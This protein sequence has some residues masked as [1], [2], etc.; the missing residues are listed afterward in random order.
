MDSTIKINVAQENSRSVLKES[1]HNAPYKLVHYGSRNL[2]E[3][4]ELIIMSASPGVMD[5]DTLTIHMTLQ[6]HS[7]L[8][9]YTQAFNKLHPMQEGAQQLIEVNIKEDGLF[10]YIP[11]PTTPF[12]DSIYKTTN[13]IYLHKSATLIWGDIICGG[14]VHRN[15]CFAFTRLHSL[16]KVHVNGIPRYIDNQYLAPK[17]QPIKKMLFFEGYTHQGTLLY[18]SPYAREL[19]LELD[20][21]L[22]V[23]YDEITYGFTSC[24]DDMIMIRVLG[25]EGESLYNFM[26]MLGQLCWDYTTHKMEEKRTLSLTPIHQS[27]ESAKKSSVPKQKAQKITGKKATLSI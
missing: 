6:P 11:H 22:R 14:R 2:H 25:Y 27:T 13:N 5:G 10:Q 17:E 18:A 4:L 8:K 19:K 16:T 20:E 24:A 26:V 23:E 15:E 1:F 9:L 3:H 7:S 12:K 21:I